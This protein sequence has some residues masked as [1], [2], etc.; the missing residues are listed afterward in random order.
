MS[1]L[2]KHILDN[3]NRADLE[4]FYKELKAL[5]CN[6]YE[7]YICSVLPTRSPPQ[8]KYY[9]GYLVKEIANH[10]GLTK[11]HTNEVLKLKFNLKEIQDTDGKWVKYGGS[12]EREKRG[13]VEEIYAQIRQWAAQ[14]LNLQLLEPNEVVND[15]WVYL[16]NEE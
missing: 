7:L 6:R 9:F 8:R 14:D 10:C 2:Q 11:E 4:K 12:I 15:Q 13:R 3:T 16:A 5:S 1:I